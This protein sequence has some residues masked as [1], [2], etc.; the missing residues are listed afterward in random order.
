MKKTQKKQFPTFKTDAEAE[1][2]VATADLSEY[3]F[4]KFRPVRFEFE[5]KDGRINMRM[6][7][8]LIAAV[9]TRAARRGIP[10]QKFIREVLEREVI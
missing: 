2:F 1:R 4:S 3:D 6:P 10:Y 7:D 9:K 5:K 8:S